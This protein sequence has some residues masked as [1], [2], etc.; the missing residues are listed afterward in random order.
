MLYRTGVKVFHYQMMDIH[1]GGHAKKEDLRQILEL[2]RPKFLI[3]HHGQYSMMVS[4]GELG[5]EKG[6]LE[7]NVIIA[8]NG[9]IIEPEPFFHQLPN[10]PEDI[11]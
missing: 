9:Q 2:I 3:P 4:L 6:V 1:A 7:D 8:D 10:V 11:A 5:K